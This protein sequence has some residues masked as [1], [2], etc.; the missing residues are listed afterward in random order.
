M[1]VMIVMANEEQTRGDRPG[2]YWGDP[3]RTEKLLEEMNL[4]EPI[5]N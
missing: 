4:Q 2:D 5:K 3:I 1:G